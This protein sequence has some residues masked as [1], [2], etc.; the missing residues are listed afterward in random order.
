MEP[1]KIHLVFEHMPY[2]GVSVYDDLTYDVDFNGEN[3]YATVP[4]G[5]GK[6]TRAAIQAWLNDMEFEDDED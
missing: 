2:G 4:V 6:T 5:V 3:Y 1:E